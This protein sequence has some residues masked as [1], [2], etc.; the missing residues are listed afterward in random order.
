MSK[1]PLFWLLPAFLPLTL[2]ALIL[3]PTT[4]QAH[5]QS[6]VSVFNGDVI[7]SEVAWGATAASSSDEWIE[8]FNN[9]GAAIDLTGWMLSDSGDINIVLNGTIAASAF[10]LLE[11]TADDTVSDIPAD[12]IY[13]G[14]LGNPGESLTLRDAG[15][16]LVDSA[17][18]DGD[19]WPAGSGSP[20]Y[21]SMERISPDAA[22]EDA[23]WVS[24]D[25]V[26][27]NG[28]DADGNPING[29]PRQPNSSWQITPPT[30]EPDLVASKSGPATAQPDSVIQYLLGVQ[31][32][33]SAT[34][35]TVTLTD[36]LPIGLSYVSDNSGFPLNQPNAQTLVWSLGDVLTTTSVNFQLTVAVAAN[37]S[38]SLTNQ[39]AATTTAAETNTSN[40]Q[41][42]AT[43]QISGGDTPV[44]WINAVLYDGYVTG[45]DDEAVELINAGTTPANIGGWRISDQNEPGSGA[46]LPAG[47]ILNAGD[48][49]WLTRD[50]AA[51]AHSFGH[52]PDFETDDQIA[53]VPELEGG[54]PG[55]SNDGDEVVLMDELG[56]V[57]DALVYENGNTGL[58]GWSG[59]AVQPFSVGSASGSDGQ[60][61]YRMRDQSSGWPVPDSNT[62]A[63]WAQSTS[64]VVNGR[65]VRYPGWDLE[66]FFDTAQFN[67]AAELRIAIAPDNAY[68]AI[69]DH[70]DSAQ[71]SI[72]MESLTFEN[73]GIANALIAAANRGVAVTVLL[74]G[75]PTGG[76]S[77]QEKYVC[78]ELDAAGAHCWFMISDSANGIY[79]RYTYLHAKFILVDDEW[80]AIS[81]ENMS[82]NSLPNDDKA[83]GT[84]GRRGVVLFTNAPGVVAHVRAI[85]D[86]DF[87]PAAHTDLKQWDAADPVHGAPSPGF[88]PITES[89]GITYTVRYPA[90]S[91]FQGTF[92]FEVVQSPE[93]SLRDQDSLLG[94]LNQAGAGD[95]VLVQQLDEPPHWGGSD[96]NPQADPN[97]RLEAYIDAARRG[98]TV[99]LMLDGALEDPDSATSN[100]ATC[101]Y[102]KSVARSEG[103]SMICTLGNPAGLGIHNK[104][105][106]V[107]LDGHGYVHMGSINGSEQSNKGNRE[108]ALQIQSDAAYALLADMFRRDWPNRVYVPTF[109]YN[110]QGT[111]TYPLISEVMYDPTGPDDAEFIEIANP[112]GAAIDLS[113]YALGD[114]VNVTDFEDV[115]R[116]PAGTILAP[117]DTLVI[118]AKA[119]AFQALYGFNP[120]FEIV[121]TSGSV[122]DLIDD[123]AW[124]SPETYLQ[125]GN[126]GDEVA[127]RGPDN[128]AV[129]AIAYGTGQ[130]PGVISCGVIDNGNALERYPYWRDSDDCAADFRDIFPPTPGVLPP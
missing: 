37:A 86:V 43:T 94:L 90:P 91:V 55:Y 130:F 17:N 65:K 59:A 53:E 73:L 33:G 25:G 46:A 67:Q 118:A 8:L 68:E 23:N 40:N 97:L 31:N 21:Y 24:N 125:L 41:A 84:W 26:T 126:F 98:A 75:G 71:T 22:D 64:D 117:R 76:I 109:S 111:A 1:R 78:Q 13:T 124:G 116:F 99:E 29:T 47:V 69:V 87:D 11:R 28:L 92:A 10:F 82:L 50:A 4:S 89:G 6:G 105:V 119:V 110:F 72:V 52:L 103:L 74:E 14:N 121:D 114:A 107:R 120:D 93:N 30:G 113:N 39:I 36:T 112:T 122:P 77:D 60:I 15:S 20:G 70:I 27:R 7:I 80:V 35:T 95:L 51:F 63:D 3:S 2:L 129:D 123:P 106:L 81:S 12:Q 54:W 128:R 83:D 61:L 42:S 48:R 57:V 45:D 96:S 66:Q 102:V 38:G 127:L 100:Q 32:A 62:A 79:D 104:M 19:V 58:N 18:G 85:F 16:A 115:R 44:V 34:V 88:V 9:T 49:I 101:D 108:L 5:N 56:N